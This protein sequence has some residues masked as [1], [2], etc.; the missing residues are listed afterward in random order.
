MIYS[1]MVKIMCNLMEFRGGSDTGHI[2]RLEFFLRVLVKEMFNRDLYTGTLRFWNIESF[3]QSAALHDVGKITLPEGL[4]LKPGKLTETEY[5][6]MKKHTLS[7]ENIIGK[8]MSSFPESKF[9]A[10]AQIIAGTHHEKWDGT[11]YPRGLAGE[12]IPIEGRLVALADVF[13]T[14]ISDRSYKK[15]RPFGEA[16]QIIKAERGSRFDPGVVD[17]FVAAS[18]RLR[19]FSPNWEHSPKEDQRAAL[20]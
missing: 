14:L 17:A 5:N 9:L 1:K 7:G 12:H 3:Y 10:Q 19:E 8:A 6:E 13:D 16:I 4:L 2:E 15:A 18:R 20:A 11:G